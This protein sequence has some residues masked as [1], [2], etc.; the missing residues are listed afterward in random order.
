MY[1]C[2]EAYTFIYRWLFM[3]VTVFVM[4]L[5]FY[6]NF[7]LFIVTPFLVL[8]K[9]YE[10]CVL[11]LVALPVWRGKLVPDRHLSPLAVVTMETG[12]S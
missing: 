9:I 7:I 5:G 8:A 2:G 6:Y 4:D 12:M 11:P 10:H 3:Y 1:V